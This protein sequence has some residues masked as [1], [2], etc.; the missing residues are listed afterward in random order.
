LRT[1][2]EAAAQKLI[3]RL[4]RAEEFMQ[5]EQRKLS[6]IGAVSRAWEK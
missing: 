3:G 1:A 5:A 2:Y 4:K 6:A